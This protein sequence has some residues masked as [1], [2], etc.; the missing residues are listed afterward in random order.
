MRAE[1]RDV[2]ENEGLWESIRITL[3]LIVSYAV[4]KLEELGE[5][6]TKVHRQ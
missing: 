1:E 4:L 5:T 2:G 3:D 6:E